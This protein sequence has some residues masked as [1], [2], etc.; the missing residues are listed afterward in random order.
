[1]MTPYS[2]TL[3]LAISSQGVITGTYF[4]NSIRPDPSGG[5]IITVTG[6]LNGTKL[7][8]RFGM[9][10]SIQVDGTFANGKM[11]GVAHNNAQVYNFKADVE[12]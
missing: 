7:H 3:T 11:K 8:L 1:M 12:K 10:G 5:R 9:A 4:S 2:G 6:T